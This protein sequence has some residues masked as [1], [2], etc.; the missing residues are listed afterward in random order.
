MS[1]QKPEK[2]TVREYQIGI[3]CALATETIAVVGMLDNRHATLKTPLSNEY[4]HHLGT[5]EGFSVTILCLPEIGTSSAAAA[6]SKMTAAFTSI[7]L[8]ILVGVAGG[9]PPRVRKG[10]VIVTVPDQRSSGVT[11]WDLSTATEGGQFAI[12]GSLNRPPNFA[13]A[14]INLL[15]MKHVM[16]GTDRPKYLEAFR[17][18]YPGLKKYHTPDQLQD[19]LYESDYIHV[20]AKGS[21]DTDNSGETCCQLCDRT[22]IV[23]RSPRGMVVHYG[24]IATGNAVIRDAALR[25]KLNM[26][27]GGHVL[28][29]EM[30]AGGLMNNFPCV[31]VRG[32]C[33]YCDS[34][35]DKTWQAHAATNAAVVAKELLACMRSNGAALDEEQ[36]VKDLIEHIHEH[37]TSMESK[38][39]T[40]ENQK[41]LNWITTLNF[42]SRHSDSLHL[43][44]PNTGE[45]LLES[46]EFKNFL[47]FREK[48]LFCPGM[49]GAGKSVLAAIVVEALANHFRNSEKQ[50]CVAFVCCDF[51]DQANQ[52]LDALLASLLKQLSANLRHFPDIIKLLYDKHNTQG[53][54]PSVKDITECLHDIASKYS[55][56]F[57]VVDGLDE[58]PVEGGCRSKFISEILNLQAQCPVS[59]FATSRN[60]PDVTRLFQECPTLQIYATSDDVRRYLD[61]RMCELVMNDETKCDSDLKEEIKTRIVEVNDGMFLLAKLHFDPLVEMSRLKDIRTAL[62]KLTT[63]VRAY[64][65]AYRAVMERFQGQSSHRIN[66]AKKLLS[67]V[68]HAQ[69]PLSVLELQHALAVEKGTTG[70]DPENIPSVKFI[71]SSCLGLVEIDEGSDIVR[72]AHYTV[73]EFFLRTHEEW[74][75]NYMYWIAEICI[76][77]LGFDA[78]SSGPSPNEDEYIKRRTENPFLPYASCN[79]AYHAEAA[80]LPTS[81]V[82]SFL[83][84]KQQLEAAS[85]GLQRK[86]YWE[87]RTVEKIS[88]EGGHSQQPRYHDGEDVTP[89]HFVAH[90][91]LCSV[92]RDLVKDDGPYSE[93]LNPRTLLDETPLVWAVTNGKEA[94]VRLLLESGA[95]TEAKVHGHDQTF[96]HHDLKNDPGEIVKL[97]H[98]N[99][100]E[101]RK[102][103]AM[104]SL[105]QS[106]VDTKAK[107]HGHDQTV[108]L[109]ALKNNRLDIVK[110]LLENNADM[111]VSN[112]KNSN[113][114]FEA[115]TSGGRDASEAVEVIH[116]GGRDASEAV[117]VIPRGG[118]DAPEAV[119]AVELLLDYGIDM[120]AMG[121]YGETPFCFAVEWEYN[122]IVKLLL[123]RGA[124]PDR[125]LSNGM[126]PLIFA[127]VRP[128][129][130]LARLLLENKANTET[131]NICSYESN[132]S[133]F[134]LT[135]LVWIMHHLITSHGVAAFY[136]M[137]EY[138]MLA[139]LL[140]EYKADIEA[141][142]PINSESSLSLAAR[143]NAVV[144]A[145]VLLR[146][147]ADIQSKDGRGISPIE[148]ALRKGHKEVAELLLSKT[149]VP[150]ASA[151]RR[152]RR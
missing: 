94:V 122:S 35:K 56:V 71:V 55:R 49:P 47:S 151:A 145:E 101:K 134:V 143:T 33:D 39:S 97:L 68:L 69:W 124:N 18:N 152:R 77:Y 72:L 90:F 64:D 21:G 115:I 24:A 8:V 23:Q 41:I 76:T 131:K 48:T 126:T 36:S 13:I 111:D 38:I 144:I 140:L 105:L 146:H 112:S 50:I 5:M 95:D 26:N 61:D 139:E 129:L 136:H 62:A 96:L 93:N 84:K 78:F 117:E 87:S 99:D 22:K 28:A 98:G 10:D 130:D 83:G 53:T 12:K 104:L 27:L 103:A 15:K 63:G 40:G 34:H 128:D 107:V 2:H 42:G 46:Q 127:I 81:K 6:V 119:E 80:S 132:G 65:N 4:A 29:V 125:W 108:L 88:E 135:P 110:L 70:L 73:Q 138:E 74:F 25:D 147:G 44:T 52:K 85:Q 57:A 121:G 7:K 54:R 148:H 149:S 120:E 109:H 1:S 30:E 32:I 142:H 79:W 123:Q 37:V 75:P 67:L 133:T 113:L 31:V 137:K 116:L 3:I 20:T 100:V 106:G 118:C 86:H 11:Q 51:R 60:I 17:T 43:R 45:W 16:E 82:M 9:I 102:G 150:S 91:G 58:G 89:L 92:I 14:A 66:D 114:L 19:N 141:K 59:F